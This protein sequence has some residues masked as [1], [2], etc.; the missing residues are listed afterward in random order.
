MRASTSRGSSNRDD[1]SAGTRI[2][3]LICVQ[4]SASKTARLRLRHPSHRNIT[5]KRAPTKMLRN[6]QSLSR[7]L[8]C[9]LQSSQRPCALPPMVHFLRL[10]LLLLVLL[11]RIP[12]LREDALQVR[13]HNR[14][15]K[16]AP[17]DMSALRPLT[18][19]LA[20]HSLIRIRNR[21]LHHLH[22]QQRMR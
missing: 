5:T 20:P 10:L 21:L 17:K 11:Q 6:R 22:P 7:S 4:G 14:R 9:H 15:L 12:Q 2:R 3:T 19:L 16:D 18:C 1:S 8:P 13:R